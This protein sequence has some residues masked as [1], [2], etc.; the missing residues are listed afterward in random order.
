MRFILA[1]AIV[2]LAS[3]GFAASQSLGHLKKG[4]ILNSNGDQCWYAQSEKQ[5]TYLHS[6]SANTRTLVF[7]DPKCMSAEGF[8]LKVNIM[9]IGN[10][11]TKP[12]SHSDASF[13][14]KYDDLRPSSPLQVRGVCIQSRTYPAVGVA[15]EFQVSSGSIV[16]VK[17]ATAIQGCK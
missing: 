11:I 12:Y 17:H 8:D 3:T 1:A 9:M 6:A 5:E 14:T 15:V 2:F 13:Q 4:Y 16:S 10:I 7:D